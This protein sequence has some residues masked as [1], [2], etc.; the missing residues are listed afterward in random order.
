MAQHEREMLSERTKAALQAA[1]KRGQSTICH[2]ANTLAAPHSSL[3]RHAF[4]DGD[5]EGDGC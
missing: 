3:V 5:R 2:P 4:G 1:K